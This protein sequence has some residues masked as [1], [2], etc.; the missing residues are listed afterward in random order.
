VSSLLFPTLPGI[1][2]EVTRNYVWKTAVQE[3]ISGKMTAL[4]LRQY[5]LVHYELIVNLLRHYL[6]PSE[7]LELQGL[8]NQLQ[9]RGDTFLYSDPDFNTVTLMVMATTDGVT[10]AFPVT[11]T[12]ENAGGPGGPELIQNFNGTAFFFL[13]RFGFPE[14]IPGYSRTIYTLYDIDLTNSDWQKNN[15]TV[16]GAGGIQTIGGT[17]YV[18]S[19]LTENTNASVWH[20]VAQSC[21]IP[22]TSGLQYTFSGFFYAGGRQWVQLIIQES[23]L[24]QSASAYFNLSGAGTVGTVSFNSPQWS[25]IF[26][27]IEASPTQPGWYKCTITGTKNT[28]ANTMIV[29]ASTATADTVNT[30]AGS[31]GTLALYAWGLQLENTGTPTATVFTTNAQITQGD[32]SLGATGIVTTTNTFTP[33]LQLLWSGS[34]YYRCRFDEDEVVWSKFMYSHWQVKKLGFTSVK[35]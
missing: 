7:L 34:F 5:P 1:G 11:A 10:T 12:F 8:Y 31:N 20:Y 14:S 17:V 26:T 15:L 33:G 3:A 21:P 4:P 25:S 18:T 6:V 2:F 27:S 16:A 19:S 23:S 22:T 35:L 30:Y 24:L 28:T 29:Y 32:V 9:G 13:N